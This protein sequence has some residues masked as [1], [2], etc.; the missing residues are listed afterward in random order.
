MGKQSDAAERRQES[1]VTW[2]SVEDGLPDLDLLCL[3]YDQENDRGWIGCRSHVVGEGWLWHETWGTAH[4]DGMR[5][6]ASELE[7]DDYKVTHWCPLPGPTD[8]MIEQEQTVQP[9]FWTLVWMPAGVPI[10]PYDSNTHEDAGLLVYRSQD[11]A[12]C[13][14]EHQQAMYGNC[15]ETAAPK[16]LSDLDK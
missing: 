3:L 6:N 10:V 2:R 5:W 7:A 14:A 1:V 15:D 4:W 12:E 8:R 9:E 11:A 16:R 13:A